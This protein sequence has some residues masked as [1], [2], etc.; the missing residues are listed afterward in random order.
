MCLVT[1]LW[2]QSYLLT[3]NWIELVISTSEEV[4]YYGIYDPDIINVTISLICF[5]LIEY[6]GEKMFKFILLKINNFRKKTYSPNLL[7]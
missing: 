2:Q 3:T 4:E 5:Q 7:S 6:L 1:T